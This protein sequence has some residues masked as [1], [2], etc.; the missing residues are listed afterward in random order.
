MAEVSQTE[1]SIDIHVSIDNRRLS[2]LIERAQRRDMAA[3]DAIRNFY[4]EH[5]SFYALLGHLDRQRAQNPPSGEGD[6]FTPEEAEGEWEREMK[7]AA[8]TICGIIEDMFDV[9]AIRQDEQ[10]DVATEMA[11]TSDT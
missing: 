5:I 11:I 2:H 10:G 4:L 6:T 3:V 1:D 7:R 9:L 8:Q